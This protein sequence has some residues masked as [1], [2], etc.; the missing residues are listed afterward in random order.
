MTVPDARLDELLRLFPEAATEGKIDFARLKQALGEAADSRKEKYGLS[1]AGKSE[2]IQVL[3]TSA[4][5]TL[6]PMVDE[7]VNFESSENLIIEGDNL[8]VLKLLQKSY[9]GKVKMI[10]IDPPYNTGNEFIYPDNFKEGLDDYLK[11]SGQTSED[12]LK[13][14][15]NTESDG[16]YHS[17]WLS[18]MYPRLFIAKT[19]LRSDGLM[20]VSIDDHQVHNLRCMM[21][22]IF[23]EENF[24]SQIIIVSNK[25]GQTYKEIA[26]THEY[27][28][29]YSREETVINE[30]E[31]EDGALP[32]KDSKGAFDLWELRNRNP[33]FGRRNRPNLYF[34]IYVAP[35]ITDENGYAKVSLTPSDKFNVKVFPVNSEG[36]D[37]CWR[38]GT[39]KVKASDLSSKTPV[40]VGR[41]KKDGGWNIYEKSRKATTKA[42]SLW[43]ET[44]VISEQGTVQLGELGLA[45]I[46]DHPKP[47]GLLSKAIKIG[48]QEGDI[49][50]DFFGGSGTTAHA[51]LNLNKQEGGSRKFILVQLPEVVPPETAAHKAGFS[52]LY[53]ICA[54]R[55]RRVIKKIN[56]ERNKAPKLDQK[57]IDLGFKAFKLSSSNFKEWEPEKTGVDA[58]ALAVQLRLHIEN[59]KETRTELDIA[60]E[61]ILKLG[62]ELS[63]PLEK[64]TLAKQPVYSVA[65]GEFLLS[66][67]KKITPET[68]RAMMERKPKRIMCLDVAF[69][70]NDTL[71]TNI[72]LE[73]QSHQIEFHTV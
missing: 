37:G 62:Y 42:K 34:P 18:M 35:D 23:G 17:K 71:K 5:G 27:L 8:E 50:L 68:L 12:G 15:T 20:F 39:D 3:Q 9:Y 43:D 48:S 11:Y 70:G 6:I 60:Y 46:F 69:E 22:E 61:I 32:F 29:V 45:G 1:W 16:R 58:E 72:V 7:S 19:L 4:T 33:K 21:N 55:V 41:Q 54:E 57:P 63:T 40:L 51:V 28:L 26:K 66:V 73:M 38:W 52:N 56:D 64:L 47:L 13:L 44:E 59:V 10:Y 14:S 31:K 2:A 49:I 30:L 25:R 65:G 36:E 53:D 24:I 67:E